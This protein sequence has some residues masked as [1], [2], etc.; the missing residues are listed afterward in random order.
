MVSSGVDGLLRQDHSNRETL[1]R[2]ST[3]V[4][5]TWLC[6]GIGRI[7]GGNVIVESWYVG[8]RSVKLNKNNK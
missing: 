2:H 3:T 1:E 4:F 8:T 5:V 6:R 7:V